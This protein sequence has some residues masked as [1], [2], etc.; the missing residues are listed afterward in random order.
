[1]SEQS[2][3]IEFLKA[4]KEAV[5]ERFSSPLLSSFCIAW[6]LW[7]YKFIVI[8]FS[9]NSV[10]STFNLI[11]KIS[12][13]NGMTI[14]LHGLLYPFL[15]AIAYI[16]LYPYPAKHI[17]V[18]RLKRQK[19]INQLK[20][21]IHDETPLTV[22]ESRILIKK[23]FELEQNNKKIINSLQSE[24]SDLNEQIKNSFKS[25]AEDKTNIIYD[26]VDP[27]QLAILNL[28]EN[29]GGSANQ[30]LIIKNSGQQK[31]KTEFDLGELL[32]KNLIRQNYD[33][34]ITDYVY[35]FTQ[36]GRKTYLEQ[37]SSASE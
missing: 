28:I 14:F 37:N 32:R 34:N 17:Y 7:N 29:N 27:T 24:I 11:E 13:P 18:F 31:I 1:M 4:A 19:E 25:Q 30:K 15:S 3:L 5:S 20:K 26:R 6:C 2:E 8:L 16:Y 33:Y 23:Y 10:E 22:E 35:T 12:F 21:K 9:K 36:P